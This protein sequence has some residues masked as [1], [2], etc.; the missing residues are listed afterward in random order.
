[1]KT[2]EDITFSSLTRLRVGMGTG[3]VSQ[4]RLLESR[5]AAKGTSRVFDL[6]HSVRIVRKMGSTSS[7]RVPKTGMSRSLLDDSLQSVA[8]AIRLR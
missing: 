3:S 7:K 8:V 1:V 4:R 6:D 2:L 5:F